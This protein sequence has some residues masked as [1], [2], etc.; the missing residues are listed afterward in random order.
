MTLRRTFQWLIDCNF[1]LPNG[2]FVDD[3]FDEVVSSLDSSLSARSRAYLVLH[4]KN[5]ASIDQAI[6]EFKTRMLKWRLTTKFFKQDPL[7]DPLLL[8]AQRTASMLHYANF[9]Q[10]IFNGFFNLA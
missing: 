10:R 1:L 5:Q 9:P 4:C 6:N 2:K 3:K 7:Q 8:D